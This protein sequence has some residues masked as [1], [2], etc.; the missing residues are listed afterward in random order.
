M[1][2]LDKKGDHVGLTYLYIHKSQ[3]KKRHIYITNTSKIYIYIYF[4]K[5]V[6]TKTKKDLQHF[7]IYI[8]IHINAEKRLKV[9]YANLVFVC[10]CLVFI[11]FWNICFTLSWTHKIFYIIIQRDVCIIRFY[12]FMTKAFI[13]MKSLSERNTFKSDCV[14][15]V[16]WS[17]CTSPRFAPISTPIF[18]TIPCVPL[19]CPPLIVFDPCLWHQSI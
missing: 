15:L 18:F 4:T 19:P 16:L 17:R 3:R 8:Y 12:F 5:N 9:I 10:F 11:L 14:S 7:Q 1:V 6:K 13:S 2:T